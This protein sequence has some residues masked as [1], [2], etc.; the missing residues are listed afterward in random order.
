MTLADFRQLLY[1]KEFRIVQPLLHPNVLVLSTGQEDRRSSPLVSKGLNFSE[2]C[3][4]LSEIAT[5][6]WRLKQ[7]MIDE[8]NGEPSE[9]MRR[10]YRHVASALDAL[11]EVGIEIQNHTGQPYKS[12]LAVEV[13]AFQPTAEIAREMIVETVRPSIYLN[14]KQV[15]Q[16]QVIV[17]TPQDKE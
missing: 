8:Q 11:A 6:L 14:E 17:G 15:Q 2:Q 13:L 12:G 1:P 4:L 16:G 7:K 5:E 10:P 3:R 9:A